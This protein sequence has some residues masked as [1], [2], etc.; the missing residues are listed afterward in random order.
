MLPANEF[1]HRVG[2]WR[3]NFKFTA[4]DPHNNNPQ[5]VQVATTFYYLICKYAPLLNYRN[6]CFIGKVTNHHFKENI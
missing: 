5:L 1:L 4:F 3:D 6:N 2:L